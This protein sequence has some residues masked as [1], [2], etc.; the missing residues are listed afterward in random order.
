MSSEMARS[1]TSIVVLSDLTVAVAVMT[2][3]LVSRISIILIR[4]SPGRASSMTVALWLHRRIVVGRLLVVTALVAHISLRMS[5]EEM[6]LVAVVGVD[7]ES[8]CTSIP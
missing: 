1:V 5:H 8:P 6:A 2:I 3:S 4:I 7:I